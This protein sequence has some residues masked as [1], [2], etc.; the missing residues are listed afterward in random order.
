MAGPMEGIRVVE[1][2]FWVAGPSAAGILA[3][4]GADVIKIE[5]PDG[6]PFRGLFLN[7]A[8]L[9][10]PA[11]PPFELDNRGKRSIALDFRKDEGRN[12]ALRLV[13]RA[14]VV[15]TNLRPVVLARLGLD[16]ESLTE[17]NPRL[18]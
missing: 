9:E 1:L 17:R 5:P 15:V 3:D 13:D 10:V 2:A 11:N 16:P 6:D 7:A 8:G 14:D 18:V 12:I 4:W